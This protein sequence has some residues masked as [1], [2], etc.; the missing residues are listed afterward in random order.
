MESEINQ[1]KC[2][3]YIVSRNAVVGKYV[4]HRNMHGIGNKMGVY[5]SAFFQ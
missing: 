1:I 2:I 5:C 4:D 3:M